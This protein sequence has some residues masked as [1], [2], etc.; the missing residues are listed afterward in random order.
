M[1][2]IT[3]RVL[4][5]VWK[6]IDMKEALKL[7][8]HACVDPKMA[9]T[10]EYKTQVVAPEDEV[11]RLFVRPEDEVARRFTAQVAQNGSHTWMRQHC[12]H[13]RGQFLDCCSCQTVYKHRVAPPQIIGKNPKN[14][15]FE[16]VKTSPGNSELNNH[17][18][19]VGDGGA[20]A[21]SV[22]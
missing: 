8:D 18:Y 22:S 4:R 21:E 10:S 9:M 15:K 11:A 20:V 17:N 2:P 16:T 14:P 19:N 5:K 12:K 6:E 3:L 7:A 1:K 13:S